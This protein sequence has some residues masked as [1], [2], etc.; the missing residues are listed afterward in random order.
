M[1]LDYGSAMAVTISLVIS[2]ITIHAQAPATKAAPGG[3]SSRA[4]AGGGIT[5]P[6]WTGQIDASEAR[7]G[8]TLDS[9]KFALE[10]NIMKITTGPAVTYWNPK[11]VVSGTI[12]SRQLS[13]SPSI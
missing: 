13:P 7:A 9:A 5:V 4:V 10:G 3:D 11:N 1:R 2:S 12:P 6:G 8:L